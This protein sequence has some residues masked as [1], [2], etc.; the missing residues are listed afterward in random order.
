MID[1]NNG[2]VLHREGEHWDIYIGNV[3]HYCIRGGAQDGMPKLYVRAENDIAPIVEEFDTVADA[4]AELWRVQGYDPALGCEHSPTVLAT[5]AN[6]VGLIARV[7]H[8]HGGPVEV[9]IEFP[10]EKDTK[11]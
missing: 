1:H 8:E 9:K 2:T 10:N 11:A 3:R 7:L 4:M 6:V 5:S